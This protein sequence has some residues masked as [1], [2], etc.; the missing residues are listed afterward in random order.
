MFRI[1][2]LTLLVLLCRAGTAQDV[3]NLPEFFGK[4]P[5]RELATNPDLQN[6]IE[7][8]K[9]QVA[10]VQEIRVEFDSEHRAISSRSRTIGNKEAER[11][12][13][14]LHLRQAK[15]TGARLRTVFTPAQYRRL[16]QV[17]LQLYIERLGVE[18]LLDQYIVAELKLDDEDDLAAWSALVKKEKRRYRAELDHLWKEKQDLESQALTQKQHDNLKE[19]LGDRFDVQYYTGFG[20][21]ETTGPHLAILIHPAVR[22]ELEVIDDQRDAIRK[23]AENVADQGKILEREA[24][25][26]ARA[27]N[28]KTG[29][30]I[31][32]RVRNDPEFRKSIAELH[33][34]VPK[35]L[36]AI[37]LPHQMKRLRQLLFQATLRTEPLRSPVVA[38]AIGLTEKE[39]KQIIA[40]LDAQ[41]KR[42]TERREASW[43]GTLRRCIEALPDEQEAAYYRLIGK[44]F[45]PPKY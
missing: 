27:K 41:A 3:L 12:F 2:T 25:D 28:A 22:Q 40:K 19:V 39:H 9:E 24:R 26:A 43:T 21:S 29:K 17:M 23:L 34:G 14:E 15:V 45:P 16:R 18:F 8:T 31:T 6:E 35:A 44:P 7:A 13:N 5:L 38:R 4:G 20:V 37:L 1:I 42:S 32:P 36:A 33:D 10:R 11:L 30:R